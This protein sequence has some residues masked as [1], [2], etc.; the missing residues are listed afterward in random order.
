M[1]KHCKIKEV[2]YYSMKN[3]MEMAIHQ[4][5]IKFKINSLLMNLWY[6]T[7]NHSSS[8]LKILISNS[9]K[10]ARISIMN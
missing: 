2:K 7:F 4:L 8:L 5:E 10:S 1:T 6:Y 9:T 3:N